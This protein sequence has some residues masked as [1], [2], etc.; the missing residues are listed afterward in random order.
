M[1]IVGYW[2]VLKGRR[3]MPTLG[4]IVKGDPQLTSQWSGSLKNC[5]CCKCPKSSFVSD[6]HPVVAQLLWA[7]LPSAPTPLSPWA[8]DG[9]AKVLAHKHRWPLLHYSSAPLIRRHLISQVNYHACAPVCFL[10]S[11]SSFPVCHLEY[12]C[13]FELICHTRSADKLD[14]QGARGS[15]KTNGLITRFIKYCN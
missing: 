11:S 8:F 1:A 2:V 10:F 5:Y 9:H 12:I 15:L 7:T 6:C 4:K 13:L 3:V 14:A